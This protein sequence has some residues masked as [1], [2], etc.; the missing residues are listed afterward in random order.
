[1]TWAVMIDD[2]LEII[3]YQIIKYKTLH[4]NELKIIK[5]F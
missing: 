1:M 5:L 4:F 2:S 3:F